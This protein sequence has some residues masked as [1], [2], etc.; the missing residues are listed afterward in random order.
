MNATA[1]EDFAMI[2][3][4]AERL[5]RTAAAIRVSF[6]WFGVRKTL[7]DDQKSQAANPFGAEGGYLSASKKLLDI[8]APA[9]K[10]LTKIK[11]EIRAYW[12]ACTLPYTEPGIRVLKRDDVEAF[13]Q[14]MKE[15]RTKLA[16]AVADLSLAYAGLRA[17]ARNHLGELYCPADYPDSLDGT[18]LVEWDWPS[19]EPPDYLATVNPAIY[20]AEQR[21]LAARMEEV[22]QLSEQAF[23]AEFAKLVSHLTERLSVGETGEQK[24]FRDSA[25][26]NLTEFF[27]RFKNLNL[28]SNAALDKLAEQA[29]QL[30][31]GVRPQDLRDST[32]LRQELATQFSA[33]AASVDGMMVN[34]PRRNVIRPTEEK[35][36]GIA[37]PGVRGHAAGKDVVQSRM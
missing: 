20:E 3:T 22:V 21:R 24:V 8:K 6:T 13:D 25:V 9:Y 37:G 1:T 14:R 11:G 26:T 30:V 23:F 15:F 18:F 12:E 36:D 31:S 2:E 29:Q 33:I 27:Q 19:L 10:A 7:S 35:A 4:P 28:N 17:E 16:N 5:R 34:R 32:S